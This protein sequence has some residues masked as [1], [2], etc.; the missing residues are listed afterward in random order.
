MGTLHSVLA[1]AWL[2]H[3]CCSEL[4]IVLCDPSLAACRV[5]HVDGTAVFVD[6]AAEV[7]VGDGVVFDRGE[8]A[9]HEEGGTITSLRAHHLQA[10]ATSVSGGVCGLVVPGVRTDQVTTGDLCWRTKRCVLEKQLRA[11]YE[12][13]PA[14]ERRRVSVDAALSGAL[15]EPVE[16]VLTVRPAEHCTINHMIDDPLLHS[17]LS[18]HLNKSRCLVPGGTLRGGYPA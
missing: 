1:L 6:L 12:S 16:M 11:S 9:L 4:Y 13:V 14:S 2:R 8:P 18:Y 15:G 17:Q 10:D 3:V 5:K 7:S